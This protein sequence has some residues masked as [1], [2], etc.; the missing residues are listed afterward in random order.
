[1]ENGAHISKAKKLLLLINEATQIKV[2]RY[3]ARRDKPHHLG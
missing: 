3:I 1:M 2:G